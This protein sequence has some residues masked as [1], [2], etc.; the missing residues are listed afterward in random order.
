MTTLAPS[1]VH[2]LRDKY[3]TLR[4]LREQ[5]H[6]VAP[7]AELAALAARFPGALR[8]LDRLPLDVIE[9][10]WSAIDAVVRGVAE[11]EP[12]MRLQVAYHGFMRAVL[13]IRRLSSQA[14]ARAGQDAITYLA[15]VG[16]VPAVDEPPLERFDD[17]A[18]AIIAKPPRGRINPWVIAQVARDHDVHDDVVVRALFHP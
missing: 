9:A 3:Q 4:R 13:R 10:R 11:P 6:E 2:A 12:W 5:T 7:R 15:R 16:Y 18:L 8:E 14:E 17:E 1:L